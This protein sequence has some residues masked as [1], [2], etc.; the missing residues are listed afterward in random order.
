M[1]ELPHGESLY[2]INHHE[3]NS[4]C[5]QYVLIIVRTIMQNWMEACV[6]S[7]NY[8]AAEAWK[9]S[10]NEVEKLIKLKINK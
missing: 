8:E 9:Q 5:L 3:F 1:Y 10:V 4:L 7:E 2:S 6:E